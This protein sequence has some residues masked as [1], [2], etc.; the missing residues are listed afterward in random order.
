MLTYGFCEISAI[1]NSHLY[2]IFT[3]LGTFTIYN[4]Q[5]IVKFHLT[6]NDSNHLK[7]VGKNSKF[8][9]LIAGL[10]GL[11][12]GVLTIYL[13]QWNLHTLAVSAIVL[14][15]TVFYVVRIGSRNLRDLPFL[16]IHL[17]SIIWVVSIAIF[18]L[19]NEQVFELKLWLFG[20]THYFYILAICIPFDI[21][22]LTFDNLKQRTI[23]QILGVQSSKMIGVLLLVVFTLTAV[24]FM[25][26][27]GTN[28]I[29]IVAVMVQAIL[30]YFSSRSQN[31]LYFG[32]YIDGAIL[33]LGISYLL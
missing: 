5:R 7:W 6:P 28:K 13:V 25:P 32:G 8:L 9:I 18:P 24:Y 27:L 10:A 20:L 1:P 15:V 14:L 22:D 12:T 4:F 21:R 16:K 26:S 29:F 2:G 11:G 19:L 31:D 30:I 23:P 17:I 33:I 3:L